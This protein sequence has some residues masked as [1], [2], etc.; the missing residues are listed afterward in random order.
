MNLKPNQLVEKVIEE[1]RLTIVHAILRDMHDYDGRFDSDHILHLSDV[2]VKV[3]T[4]KLS[5][6]FIEDME[7]DITVKE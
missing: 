2:V 4:T 5:E 6:Q 3:M 1:T 7:A